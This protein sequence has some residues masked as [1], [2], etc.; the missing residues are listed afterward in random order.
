ME[1]VSGIQTAEGRP[2]YQ[3]T[4]TETV[5]SLAGYN[6]PTGSLLILKYNMQYGS[7][8]TKVP[9]GIG[10][11]VQG[12]ESKSYYA[13]VTSYKKNQTE[14]P[15][16]TPQAE[17]GYI[18]IEGIYYS[19]AYLTGLT[20]GDYTVSEHESGTTNFFFTPDA[21]EKDPWYPVRSGKLGADGDMLILTFG[22][23]PIPK[24]L[25]LKIRKSV[26][27]EKATELTESLQNGWQTI[28]FRLYDLTTSNDGDT[29]QMPLN[30]FEVDDSNVTFSG[31]KGNATTAD[32][33]LKSVHVSAPSYGNSIYWNAQD[34]HGAIAVSIYGVRA[35]NGQEELLKEVR[36]ASQ[37]P[38]RGTGWRRLRA[39]VSRLCGEVRRIRRR[40]DEA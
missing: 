22:N 30:D 15:G 25:Q 7:D 18:C 27:P 16:F 23:V 20:P 3:I 13:V 35:D 5:T 2:L 33:R 19:Y 40:A 36:N 1:P 11:D 4:S 14:V 24:E 6:T 8:S 29:I 34:T 39:G 9:D 37:R 38:E 10:F 17:S 12:P 26:N 28:G 21:N 32:Y 31:A